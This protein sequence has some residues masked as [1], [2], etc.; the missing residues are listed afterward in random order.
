MFNYVHKLIPTILFSQ[1]H[2]LI[3]KFIP[4]QYIYP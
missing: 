3:H 2:K 4:N 1:T